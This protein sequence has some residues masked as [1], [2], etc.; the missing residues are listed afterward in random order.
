MFYHSQDLPERGGVLLTKI[1]DP[2][3]AQVQARDLV[4]L[5]ADPTGGSWEPLPAV[6]DKVDASG[7]ENHLSYFIPYA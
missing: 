3:S 2:G 4:W 6:F 1:A 5:D 7:L